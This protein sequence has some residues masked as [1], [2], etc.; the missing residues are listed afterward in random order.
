[1][2]KRLAKIEKAGLNVLDRGILT[3]SILVHYEDGCHQDIGNRCLDSYNGIKR[4]GTAYGCEMIR[5]LLLELQVNDFS[6]MKG[7]KVWVHGEGEGLMFNP[8]GVSSLRVDNP[9]SNP[10][11]YAD[12]YH[13][14]STEV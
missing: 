11:M 3:F 9:K 14:F 10:V 7:L 12:I 6:E 4:V 2:N 8:H 1:M 5:R 13:D